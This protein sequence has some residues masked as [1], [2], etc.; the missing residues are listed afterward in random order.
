MTKKAGRAADP[1]MRL[2]REKKKNEFSRRFER[3]KRETHRQFNPVI[4]E[5]GSG[6]W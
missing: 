5:A 2:K 3:S 4:P 6:T 1:S